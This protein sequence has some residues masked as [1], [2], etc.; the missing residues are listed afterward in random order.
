M[1]TITPTSKW[2]KNILD[3][4]NFT[5]ADIDSVM[6]TTDA[7]KEIMQRDI[8][9]VP[10]LRG[11]TIITLFYEASTR[12]RVSFE[13]AGKILSADVIN[14]TAQS[15]S[16]SKGES[17]IDTGKTL[18]ATGADIIVIRHPSSGAAYLL[19]Q[20]VNCNVINAGDGWHAHPSQA[21]LDL[22][23]I[24]EKLK[25]LDNLKVTL[26]GDVLHSRV[27]RSNIWGL[28]NVGAEIVLCAP[29]TLLPKIF[30]EA[31]P[32][33]GKGSLT[34][35]YDVNKAVKD[36]D[37]IMALRLQTERQ[38]SGLLPSLGE[39]S[40]RWQIT[41]KRLELAKPGVMLMHPGPVNRGVEVSSELVE[42][43][44]SVIEEQVKNGVAV[45]MAL[46]YMLLAGSKP[47]ETSLAH[48]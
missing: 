19:A 15:S 41:P 45:R 18:Q 37:V 44:S 36:A 21:L 39:Y 46:L 8:R 17:L 10:A 24:R 48:S 40:E 32:H 3:L 28:L 29:P 42:H 4:D 35:E 43:E 31:Y 11:K 22:Y 1:T 9:K 14:V 26:V 2:H 38:Q 34:I 33:N 12:T 25:R 13:Q 27:A 23:T 47:N 30:I 7:M 16:I 6:Q 20:N 5:R